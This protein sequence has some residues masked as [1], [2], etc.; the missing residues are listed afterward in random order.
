MQQ[1]TQAEMDR[2]LL[3]NKE[4]MA[5]AANERYQTIIQ[6][7][8]ECITVSDLITKIQTLFSDDNIGVVFSSVH[9]AKGLEAKRIYQYKPGLMPHPKA[10]TEEEKEQE[11]HCMYVAGTRSL[12]ELYLVSGEEDG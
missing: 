3:K 12:D 1:F 4:M 11:V 2:W 8:A 9:R 7:M 10:K 5:E 6:V